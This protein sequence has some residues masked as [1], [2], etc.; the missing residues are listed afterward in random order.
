MWLVNVSNPVKILVLFFQICSNC[1]FQSQYSHKQG[2]HF[3]KKR[4]M[5]IGLKQ[6][7]KNCQFCVQLIFFK[8]RKSKRRKSNR[9]QP[10]GTNSQRV[11]EILS[12]FSFLFGCSHSPQKIL[13]LGGS[14][15]CH[16]TL[17][18][19]ILFIG[20]RLWGKMDLPERLDEL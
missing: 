1:V 15:K 17:A 7:Y 4:Q 5:E 16:I 12:P 10:L 20:D 19:Q 13:I 11:S 14:K 6:S 18:N 3:G 9:L 8:E 2:H